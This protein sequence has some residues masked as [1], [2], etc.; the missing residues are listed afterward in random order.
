MKKCLSII[1]AVLLLLAAGSCSSFSNRGEVNNPM[2]GSANQTSLSVDRVLLTDSAT[3]SI[4]T[5]AWT[6]IVANPA[7]GMEQQYRYADFCQSS[8]RRR[9]KELIELV[10][11]CT[12]IEVLT[13]QGDHT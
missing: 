4:S 8:A 1:A 10:E 13:A 2:I 6:Y 11:S 12:G 9:S 5:V 7:C 3:V